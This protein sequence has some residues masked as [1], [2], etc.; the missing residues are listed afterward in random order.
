MKGT[1]PQ[2]A[3]LMVLLATDSPAPEPD[4]AELRRIVEHIATSPEATTTEA[5]R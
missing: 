5:A 1:D 4:E 2:L 3:R